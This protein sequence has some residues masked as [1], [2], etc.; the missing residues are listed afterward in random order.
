MLNSTSAI[1]L[2]CLGAMVCLFQCS[3]THS[4]SACF[5]RG[6]YKGRHSRRIYVIIR[7]FSILNLAY[8]CFFCFSDN[9]FFRS[10]IIA[11]GG[12]LAVSQ[13]F[14][15]RVKGAQGLTSILVNTGKDLSQSVS[16]LPAL[17][18]H[19]LLNQI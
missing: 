6:E 3:L 5:C 1:D 19:R 2:T 17:R 10:P 7:Y 16:F 11:I 12:M 18:S 13:H 9:F 14:L 8:V 15:V 4:S